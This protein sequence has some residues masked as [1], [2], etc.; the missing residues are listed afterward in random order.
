MEPKVIFDKNSVHFILD[1]FN[2]KV[3]ADGIIV[4]K[5]RQPVLDFIHGEII[6][7]DELAG[8]CKQ[9]LLKGDLSSLMHL[10]E[11]QTKNRE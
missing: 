4:D 6:H 1:V 3:R 9:G 2:L 10:A 8:I 5:D 11:L 7:V